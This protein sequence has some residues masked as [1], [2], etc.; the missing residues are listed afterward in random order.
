VAPNRA[1][2]VS[3]SA[4]LRAR[5]HIR[6][7]DPLGKQALT[8]CVNATPR[9]V[10]ADAIVPFTGKLATDVVY[11]P[12]SADPSKLKRALSNAD[13]IGIAH[14]AVCRRNSM[15]GKGIGTA[16]GLA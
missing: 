15:I 10:L 14:V 6:L 7:I 3:G 2:K 16:R 12:P 4:R 11:R 5:L 8:L 13:E 9:Q 1:N